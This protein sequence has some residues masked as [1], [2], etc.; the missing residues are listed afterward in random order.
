M[1]TFFTSYKNT[2][3]LA[4]R[5]KAFAKQLLDCLKWSDIKKPPCSFVEPGTGC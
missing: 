3:A 1:K 2:F 5:E 4:L